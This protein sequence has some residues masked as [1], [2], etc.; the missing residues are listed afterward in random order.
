MAF[1][2]L[3]QL[4]ENQVF[5]RAMG[6]QIGEATNVGEED[7]NVGMFLD[8]NSPKLLVRFVAV[9]VLFHVVGNVLG[10][11]GKELKGKCIN[12][13]GQIGRTNNVLLFLVVPNQLDS[14]LHT[15][16]CLPE[17]SPLDQLRG[18]VLKRKMIVWKWNFWLFGWRTDNEHSIQ[19]HGQ[20]EDKLDNELAEV[21]VLS[22][23][24]EGDEPNEE[25]S[26][27]DEECSQQGGFQLEGHLR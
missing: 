16:P 19:V 9:N 17:R 5:R 15:F 7:G 26:D 8:V 11:D 2:R 18:D 21:K 20:N 25:G 10:N 24:Q 23:H 13:T 22:A 14:I 3:F 1:F 27:A 6:G 12:L 4:K